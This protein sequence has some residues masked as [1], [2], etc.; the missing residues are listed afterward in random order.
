MNT[1]AVKLI[2]LPC[3]VKGQIR[4]VTSDPLTNL[5]VRIALLGGEKDLSCTDRWYCAYAILPED[6]ASKLGWT[7]ENEQD[8][9]YH[10]LP[11]HGGCTYARKDALDTMVIGWDYNHADDTIERYD[12]FTVEQDLRAFGEYIKGRLEE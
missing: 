4:L 11:V 1:E 8:E 7:S 12:L 6:L 9:V 3:G 5:K 2:D 10:D